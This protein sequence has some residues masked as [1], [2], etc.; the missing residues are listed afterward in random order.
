MSET[1]RPDGVTVLDETDGAD[2]TSTREAL[3]DLVIRSRTGDRRSWAVLGEMPGLGDLAGEEHD[4]IGRLVV[5][6]DVSRLVSVGD[7]AGPVG[8]LHAGAI[9]EGSWADEAVHVTDVEAAITLL[10]REIVGP[11]VVLVKGAP[12]TGLG[13]VVT[14]LLEGAA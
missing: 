5:R 14:A 10:R 7:P 8:R 3:K 13:R 1:T 4:V 12:D 6:L 11:D 2:P 9:L